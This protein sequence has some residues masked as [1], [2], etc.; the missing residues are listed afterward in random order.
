MDDMFLMKHYLRKV[1]VSHYVR[2]QFMVCFVTPIARLY[3]KYRF[4]F[5]GVSEHNTFHVM[6]Q[7]MHNSCAIQLS[8]S[9]T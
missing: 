7:Q 9:G 4:P 8:C 3:A 1:N 5:F 6:S 2:N